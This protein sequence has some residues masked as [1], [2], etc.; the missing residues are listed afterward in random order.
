MSK[1]RND[2]YKLVSE[3]PIADTHEH[4]LNEKDRLKNGPHDIGIFFSQY[5]DSDWELCGMDPDKIDR[6]KDPAVSANEKWVIVKPHWPKIR[7]SAYGQMIRRSLQLLYG[8]DDFSDENIPDIQSSLERSMSPGYYQS[9]LDMCHIQHCQINAL[10]TPFYRQPDVDICHGDLCVTTLCSNLQIDVVE[11]LLGK[12]VNELSDL[13]D[14]IDLVFERHGHNAVAVKN[15]AAYTRPLHFARWEDAVAEHTLD[16]CIR[17]KWL[18]EKGERKPLEDFLTH[19]TIDKSAKYGLPYKFHTGMTS[20]CNSTLYYTVRDHA[21]DCAYLCT[22]H[23]ETNFVFMHMFYPYQH[24]ALALAKQYPN[25]YID[26]CWSWMLNPEAAVQFIKQA[27]T[28]VPIHKILVFG[29]DVSYIELLPG[30]VDIARQGIAKALSELI[31]EKWLTE[32]ELPAIIDQLF[33]GNAKHL[34]GI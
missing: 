22:E 2:I 6:L 34:F 21:A 28:S 33:T 24:E 8:F 13:T 4:L 20:G 31:E 26:M 9:I 32:N 18:I 25:A 27:I 15:Q 10:D 3:T 29:G 14:A 11:D 23:P 12:K 19:Y 1:L 17:K 5:L 16:F 7:Y 30:H